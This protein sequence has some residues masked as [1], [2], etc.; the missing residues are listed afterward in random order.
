VSATTRATA[1]SAKLLTPEQ[2]AERLGLEWPRQKG[3]QA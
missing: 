1:G 2:L 3:W